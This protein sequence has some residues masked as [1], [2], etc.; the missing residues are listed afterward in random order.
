MLVMSRTDVQAL[1]QP[2]DEG[3][4]REQHGRLG[5]HASLP[6]RSN[7]CRDLTSWTRRWMAGREPPKVRDGNSG[8]RWSDLGYIGCAGTRVRGPATHPCCIWKRQRRLKVPLGI[9]VVQCPIIVPRMSP[10]AAVDV[11]EVHSRERQEIIANLLFC[12]TISKANRRV[13]PESKPTSWICTF[14]LSRQVLHRRF[15]QK[16]RHLLTGARELGEEYID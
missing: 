16:H 13:D 12:N 8:K 2:F 4:E 7:D 9:S 6:I 3:R 1:R 14:N 10:D 15:A 11:K 5:I